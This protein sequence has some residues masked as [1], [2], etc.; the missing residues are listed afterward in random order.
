MEVIVRGTVTGISAPI[1][2]LA[3]ALTRVVL[4]PD[5]DGDPGEPPFGRIARGPRQLRAMLQTILAD[6]HNVLRDDAPWLPL[7]AR[8]KEVGSHN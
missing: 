6:V 8:A 3:G 5:N 2:S 7:D 1:P 4:R